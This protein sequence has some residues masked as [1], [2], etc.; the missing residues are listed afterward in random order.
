MSYKVSPGHLGL[1]GFFVIQSQSKS[2][3]FIKCFV[4]PFCIPYLA[5]QCVCVCVCVCACVERERESER[6][7]H[8]DLQWSMDL[9]EGPLAS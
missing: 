9:G 2:F 1:L 8:V 7:V 4:C 5:S 6:A 3:G